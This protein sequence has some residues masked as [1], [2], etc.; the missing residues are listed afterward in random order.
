MQKLITRE[1]S[2]TLLQKQFTFNNNNKNNQMIR[3]VSF[4]TSNISH[5]SS[6]KFNERVLQ[7][8]NTGF[9]IIE[10]KQEHL[11]KDPYEML[12]RK[13]WSSNL[14]LSLDEACEQ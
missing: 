14:E 5:D 7:L 4:A 11:E 1:R 3:R 2:K 12:Y 6:A 8:K 9:S 13:F 10:E